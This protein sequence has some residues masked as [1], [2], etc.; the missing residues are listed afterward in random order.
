M[1]MYFEITH[2]SVRNANNKSQSTIHFRFKQ[3]SEILNE[4]EDFIEKILNYAKKTVPNELANYLPEEHDEDAKLCETCHKKDAM[5]NLIA[6]AFQHYKRSVIIPAAFKKALDYATINA[7]ENDEICL[8]LYQA[9]IG[10][11]RFPLKKL[12]EIR[13]T[14]LIDAIEGVK[15]V[16]FDN[17]YILKVSHDDG[18]E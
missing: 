9:D 11:I 12:T 5:V 4:N 2:I 18:C 3:M 13:G 6:F 15:K 14:D 10:A 7:K 16:A 8:R 17:E 1:A